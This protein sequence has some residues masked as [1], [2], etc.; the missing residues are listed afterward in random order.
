MLGS[1]VGSSSVCSRIITSLLLSR[2][3]I[4]SGIPCIFSF[5]LLSI[6]LRLRSLL[7]LMLRLDLHQSAE[8]SRGIIVEIGFALLLK[9]L[10]VPRS[11]VFLGLSSCLGFGIGVASRERFCDH[12]R[13][14]V[15][16]AATVRL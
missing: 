11:L 7:L 5:S 9:L 4:L 6:W 1:L 10:S 8:C 2:G 16:E 12:G 3:A 13:W 15:I 14:E